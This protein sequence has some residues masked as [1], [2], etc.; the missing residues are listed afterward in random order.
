MT[1]Q[2]T[3][4]AL[5]AIASAVI[6]ALLAVLIWS[7]RPGQ[8]VIP[9]VILTLALTQWAIASGLEIAVTDLES[10]RMFSSLAYIGI[11]IVPAAWF[12]FVLEYTGRE[13]WLTR[14]TS[15]LL[16]I[17]PLLVFLSVATSR[18][19]QLFWTT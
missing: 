18:Y 5:I 15:L 6:A 19:H 8:G 7:R 1:L 3:P 17:E 10:K 12:T 9:F 13:K 14:R 11:T 4:Y 16:C 2:Y